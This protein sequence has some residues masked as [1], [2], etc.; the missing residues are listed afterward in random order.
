V[1]FRE[2]YK[3]FPKQRRTKDRGKVGKRGLVKSGANTKLPKNVLLEDVEKYHCVVDLQTGDQDRVQGFFFQDQQM[4]RWFELFPEVLLLNGTYK[5]QN[6]GCC[7]YVICIENSVGT[8]DVIGAAVLTVE[9][10]ASV[11]WMV[12]RLVS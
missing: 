6:I 12:E 10:K 4:R 8:S 2:V 11:E 3:Q 1:N 5:L 7:I 9:D